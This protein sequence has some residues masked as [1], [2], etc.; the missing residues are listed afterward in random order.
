[1][2]QPPSGQHVICQMATM[3]PRKVVVLIRWLR[4]VR[5][6]N[7][8][9]A[10]LQ[11]SISGSPRE[12]PLRNKPAQMTNHPCIKRPLW[13]NFEV[14]T[15]GDNHS[16]LS[17]WSGDGDTARQCFY[18]LVYPNPTSSTAAPPSLFRAILI[19]SVEYLSR[20]AFFRGSGSRRV[21]QVQL[22]YPLD[23]KIYITVLQKPGET[24]NLASAELITRS[25]GIISAREAK[26]SC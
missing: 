22:H 21:P 1:V 7:Y 14:A 19:L 6:V 5:D 17:S 9:S 18:V 13:Q 12:E 3:G 16:M 8:H 23:E 25:P 15:H 20:R 2:R 4:I 11:V 10:S 26:F 24:F